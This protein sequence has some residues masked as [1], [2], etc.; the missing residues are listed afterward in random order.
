MPGI[1]GI[2]GIGS[3][4]NQASMLTEMVNRMMHEPY[5]ASSTYSDDQLGISVGWVGHVGSYSDC[6]PVWNETKD[7]C[8][9]FSGEE[10]T[11]LGE[12]E[13]LRAGGHEFSSD[14]ASYLVHLYE[15][16][17]IKCLEK[18]NGW[19]SGLVVDLRERKIILFNDRYG[20]SRI[21]Y[22]ENKHGF[23]FASEA[24][25]LL[26]ILPELRQLN[27]LS[28]A[29][30]F[31]CGC[32]LQNKTLFS[33]L[34]LLPGGSAWEFSRVGE[35]KK[36][37]YFRPEDW[38]NQPLLSEV[39][40]YD[41]LRETF[42]RVLPRYYS[43]KGR[44]AVSLTGGVDSRMIMAWAQR[45]PGTVPCYTFGG[46]FRDCND[47][48]IARQVAKICGQPH[49]VIPVGHEFLS[50]FSALA[51]KTVY[52]TDGAM[53]VSGA[54][55]LYVNRKV[56]EVAPVRLTGN[57]GG[58]IFRSI[59]AFKPVRL[60]EGLFEPQF[61]ELLGT[62]EQTY[63][64]ELTGRR[65]SFVAFKQVPWHHYS[66]L[67]LEQSQ[68]TVR[69]PYLD[70]DLVSLAYQAPAHLAKGNEVFLRLIA[71]GNSEL[72]NMGT[73]RSLIYGSNTIMD[74]L[75]HLYQE[76]TFRAEYAYDYGM[77]HWLAQIDNALM[78]LHLERVFLGRHK[79]AHFRL[80]YRHDLAQYVKE[81]LLDPHTL[82]RSYV[83][84]RNLE[85]IVKQHTEG[86]GNY[87]LE[88]H[89]VLTAELIHR[90]LIEGDVV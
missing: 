54:A 56:R 22:H 15:E 61:R 67:S 86:Q 29:E 58:E 80:W 5:Y 90:Q 69:S 71:D 39:E 20:L 10:F 7:I 82:S 16:K 75:R 53:D 84:G 68:L 65:L 36:E 51:E 77:P 2:I 8:L 26:R 88:I 37:A 66:R 35:T 64:R 12:L 9:M 33:G 83:N 11:D 28:L 55:D 1:A 60:L 78:T 4:N 49:E 25:A 6:M 18:L 62:A 85:R 73:D 74:R 45:T 59:I 38:E 27:L 31:S 76:F 24:K 48:R 19:F 34:S 87:T 32:P 41:R 30:V 89:R 57:Y 72:C 3:A 70:N 52:L 46:M 50:Q 17:G 42:Q 63:V 13:D 40:Y 23:Y 47:V 43:G 81:I 44:G 14:T 79:F 21:Y